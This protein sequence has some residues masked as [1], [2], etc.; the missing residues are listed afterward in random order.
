[1]KFT[2]TKD[3]LY[4]ALTL[5]GSIASKQVNLPILVNVLI[6]AQESGVEVL[7]TNLEIAIRVQVR[8]KVDVAGSFTVP[9]KTIT[10]YVHLLTD[11]QVEIELEG[12]ELVVTG[13]QSS[14]KIKGLPGE[15]FPILPPVEEGH[16]YVISSGV[17]KDGLEKGVVAVAK[18]E[19]R[20]ELSGVYFGF[21]TER[22]AGLLLAATDSYRLAEKRVAVLQGTEMLTCIV[23]ART[24]FEMIR[25]LSITRGEEAQIRLW[26][27]PTQ[28]AMR[29]NNF[30]MTSRL[31]DGTYPDYAQIIPQTFRSTATFPADVLVNKVKSA[32]LFTVSGV[33]AVAIAI[34][35]ASGV[36][37]ISSTSTQT[38]EH[39]S[40]ID[41]TIEGEE[42]SILLNHRYVLDGLQHLE[43]EI[44]LKV[45]SADAPCLFQVK[46]KDDYLYI[47][48]PIRQ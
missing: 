37:G 25:L 3:N 27:S 11:S 46:G 19:I 1:M 38:G 44:E 29:Y 5:V 16:P 39:H 7:A 14:T 34:D 24:V 18:N 35:A 36:L 21:F 9:A 41:A 17:M 31:I 33:N 45:N 12:N 42:N 40:Q 28:I 4:Q 6:V 8:A 48:M 30:E 2:C 20:P 13:G 22:Y 26:V 43:G 15:E 23:P 32:S 10:D 47:V